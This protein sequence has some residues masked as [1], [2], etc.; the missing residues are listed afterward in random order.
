MG[1]QGSRDPPPVAL[2][3]GDRERLVKLLGLLG[4]NFDGEVAA[5]GRKAAQ[6]IRDRTN[7]SPSTTPAAPRDPAR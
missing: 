1:Y 5:A 7:A 6:F 4:S 3:P 2:P